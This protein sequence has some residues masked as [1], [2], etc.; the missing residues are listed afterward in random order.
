[1]ATRQTFQSIDSPNT[2][3]YTFDGGL[4]EERWCGS[5]DSK[6]EGVVKGLKLAVALSDA[7]DCI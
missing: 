1:M 4:S 6:A 2:P 7:L 5:Y 3:T